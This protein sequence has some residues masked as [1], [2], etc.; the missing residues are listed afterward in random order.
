ML[1]R[2]PTSLPRHGPAARVAR[3]FLLR[4]LSHWSFMTSATPA[5]FSTWQRQRIP[6]PFKKLDTS[7]VSLPFHAFWLCESSC[8]SPPLHS[9]TPIPQEVLASSQ[10]ELALS[11]PFCRWLLFIEQPRTCTLGT[12]APPC[13][14]QTCS[15]LASLGCDGPFSISSGARGDRCGVPSP[16]KRPRGRTSFTPRAQSVVSVSVKAVIR[17]STQHLVPFS[18]LRSKVFR[19]TATTLA[20]PHAARQ[21][22]SINVRWLLVCSKLPAS[23]SPRALTGWWQPFSPGIQQSSN[24]VS[25]P[26]PISS[27][28]APKPQPRL[29]QICS[30]PTS[31]PTFLPSIQYAAPL[32]Q[33]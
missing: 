11:L 33:L 18:L 10:P 31:L 22:M 3:R 15:K 24:V 29:P 13:R 8:K 12:G 4:I 19:A 1:K 27:Q 2:P 25:I 28:Q 26:L 20:R 21:S 17:S 32:D 5:P 23:S 9:S 30:L 7:S 6:H 16:A 14:T